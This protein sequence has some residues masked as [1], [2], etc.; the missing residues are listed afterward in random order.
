VLRAYVTDA[1]VVLWPQRRRFWNV[2]KGVCLV[3]CAQV[4]IPDWLVAFSWL[5][6]GYVGVVVVALSVSDCTLIFLIMDP[7][8]VTD[9][10][11]SSC[12]MSY[13]NCFRSER[14]VSLCL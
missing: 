12:L 13:L 5:Y 14:H 11:A 3:F 6:T 8:Q 9:L 1:L 4:G 10:S 7:V 2:L